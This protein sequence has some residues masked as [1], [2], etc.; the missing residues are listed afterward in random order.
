MREQPIGGNGQE[1][2]SA[3]PDDRANGS[4]VQVIT[5]QVGR[6]LNP[7]FMTHG[8]RDTLPTQENEQSVTAY[9]A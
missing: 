7:N 2:N 6:P 5:S 8:V 9:Y 4:L 3:S 1:L